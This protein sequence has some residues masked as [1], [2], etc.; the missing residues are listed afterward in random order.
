MGSILIFAV[1]AVLLVFSA[2]KLI[3]HLI[4]IARGLAVSVFLLAII[5]TGIEFDDVVLG[6]ALNVEDLDGVALGIVFGTALSLP[7]VVLAI[8]AI[9][10]PSDVSVPRDYL[11]LFALAPVTTVVFVLM[12]PLTATDG[13]ILVAMFVAFLA[14][15]IVRETRGEVPVF[16]D[17]EM[18]ESYVAARA[19][20]SRRESGA[21][22]T[23][24]RPVVNPQAPDPAEPDFAAKMPFTRRRERGGWSRLGLAALA[25]CGL[26]A[27]AATTGYGT[28]GIL[29]QFGLDGTIFGA[30]IVTLVLTI[31]DI[32]LTAEPFRRGAP[33]IGVGNVIGSVVFSVTAKLGIILLAGGIVVGP[34]V[35]S[36]HLPALIVLTCL[37]ALF[38]STGRVRRWHGFVLLGLYI[39]YWCVS[40]FAW[41]VVPADVD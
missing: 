18:Y 19:V 16:R 32:F 11:V 4:G 17:A 38:L 25:L 7:G 15:V 34:D 6:V 36:W 9:I 13:V 12:A 22:G 8:A 27:G 21:V 40:V 41:G 33:E 14:Y 37:A 20:G 39:V 30:T 24:D 10:K 23:I 3:G 2:E 26:V 5:F 28:K 31:E 35:L 1:G 29:E